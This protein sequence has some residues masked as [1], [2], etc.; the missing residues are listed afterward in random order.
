M[1]QKKHSADIDSVLSLLT[2]MTTRPQP[3]EELAV[4]YSASQFLP[5]RAC[6][7]AVSGGDSHIPLDADMGTRSTEDS[8]GLLAPSIVENK[9]SQSLPAF[10]EGA[11]MHHRSPSRAESVHH[12][13][14][15]HLARGAAAGQTSAPS[16]RMPHQWH[17]L[18]NPR[19]AVEAQQ[20]LPA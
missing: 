18:A 14:L 15:P 2:T 13:A 16:Y 9:V 3:I 1:R 10:E 8:H 20:P 6:I 11:V 17:A 12:A 7:L 19:L 5:E 4:S